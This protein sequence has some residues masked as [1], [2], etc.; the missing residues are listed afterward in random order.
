[1]QG[2]EN[3]LDDGQIGK[4][5]VVQPQRSVESISNIAA[6]PA[7]LANIGLIDGSLL[8]IAHVH[9]QVFPVVMLK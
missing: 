6:G 2:G 3:A 5:R 8:P 7:A 4:W 9:C 1:M